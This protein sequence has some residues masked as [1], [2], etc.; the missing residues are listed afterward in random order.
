MNGMAWRDMYDNDPLLLIRPYRLSAWFCQQLR[1][2]IFEVE[3]CTA[4]EKEL[5]RV[6]GSEQQPIS[7]FVLQDHYYLVP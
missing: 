4:R 2:K 1:K 6:Y 5:R 7:M 3:I